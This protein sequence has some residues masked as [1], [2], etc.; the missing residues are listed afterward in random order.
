MADNEKT[1]DPQLNNHPVNGATPVVDPTKAGLKHIRDGLY[2]YS[3]DL[4]KR[5]LTDAEKQHNEY[6]NQ[7]IKSDKEAKRLQNKIQSKSVTRLRATLTGKL[8]HVPSELANIK[9]GYVMFCLSASGG[10]IYL[11]LSVAK[12]INLR[13][14]EKEPAGSGNIWIFH[15]DEVE[16]IEKSEE[17]N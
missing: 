6:V 4:L 17:D 3:R 15:P 10:D 5:P 12:I 7:R 11:R 1:L 9:S 13:T 16:L 14:G 2:K 8:N